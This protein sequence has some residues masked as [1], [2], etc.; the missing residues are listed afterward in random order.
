[1]TR[2][3]RRGWLATTTLTAFAIAT[4][5]LTAHAEPAPTF[6]SRPVTLVVPYPPGGSADYIARS[7]AEKLS[8]R[9]AHPVV[10][11]NKA[12]AG[13]VIG[14]AGV[15]RA[16]PDGH[17]IVLTTAS[18]TLALAQ[19]AAPALDI[20]RDVAPV[21]LVATAPML[22][23][24]HK[25]FP[26]NSATDLLAYAK[27]SPDALFYGGN[28]HGGVGNLA[29]ELLKLK[30]GAS[31]TYV[32]Y[33]G[34]VASIAAVVANQ[35]PLAINDVGGMQPQLKA[36]TVKPILIAS[37]GRFSLLPDVPAL[38]ELGVNDVDI[39]AS[40]GLVAPRD[41]PL[42]VREAISQAVLQALQTPELQERF[43]GVGLEPV[44]STPQAYAAFLQ[45]EDQQFRAAV[46]ATGLD[47]T[48]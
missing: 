25:D 46:K 24:A 3:T 29:I 37:P 35:V 26:V 4:P 2:W 32:P 1:M 38:A 43:H 12:G 6:P 14:V 18:V 7:V 9:W 34:G 48:P 17:T 23:V 19:H 5:W 16:E 39:K 33:Q 30:T 44:G 11:Q 31:L 22:L 45:Q 41:T 10:V 36:G 27:A 21:G 15:V 47:A 40:L 13:G 20:L 42:A 8:Q 28:G